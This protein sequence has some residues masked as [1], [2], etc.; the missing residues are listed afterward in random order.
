MRS[1]RS[2]LRSVSGPPVVDRFADGIDRWFLVYVRD[3]NLM[4]VTLALF[5]HFVL[6]IAG[7]ALGLWRS[8]SWMAGGSLVVLAAAT[9]TLAAVEVRKFGWGGRA[10]FLL[11]GTWTGGLALAWYS[12]RTGFL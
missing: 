6:L 2:H 9:V 10:A 12:E 8:S 1:P 11:A 3:L 7:L 4:P 5:G